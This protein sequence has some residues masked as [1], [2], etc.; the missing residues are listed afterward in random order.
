MQ[1]IGAAHSV[2]FVWE[3]SDSWQSAFDKDEK[4]KNDKKIPKNI[5]KYKK[6]G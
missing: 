5:K 2:F 1:N 4:E 6:D 3:D